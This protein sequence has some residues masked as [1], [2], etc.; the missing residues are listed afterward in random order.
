MV[1]QH[2]DGYPGVPRRRT[3]TRTLNNEGTLDGNMG[4]EGA[5]EDA[6]VAAQWDEFDRSG[7]FLFTL[8]VG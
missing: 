1:Y 2:P 7:A 6:I 4:G 8:Y 3:R 5:D